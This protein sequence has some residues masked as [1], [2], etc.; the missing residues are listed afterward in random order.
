MPQAPRP[1]LPRTD[2]MAKGPIEG[3]KE[4]RT[5]FSDTLANIEATLPAP[6]TGAAGPA[7]TPPAGLPV[8]PPAGAGAQPPKLSDVFQSIEA[9]I[10]PPIEFSKVAES[11]EET[12]AGAPTSPTG[13]GASKG[14]QSSDY[15]PRKSEEEKKTPTGEGYVPRTPGV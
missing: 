15:E 8:T 10:Q 1:T 14:S 11:M 5:S 3:L 4:I 12:L 9:T 6:P 2:V 13:G 7:I